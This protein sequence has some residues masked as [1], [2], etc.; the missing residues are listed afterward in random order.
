MTDGLYVLENGQTWHLT[1]S[2]SVAV[3]FCVPN[4]S[5]PFRRGYRRC[6]SCRRRQP[7]ICKPHSVFVLGSSSSSSPSSSMPM[8]G[9]MSCRPV[10][11]IDCSPLNIY[12]SA[13]RLG[14]AQRMLVILTWAQPS[15]LLFTKHY[16]LGPTIFST[17]GWPVSS[18]TFLK[19][20]MYRCLPWCVWAA[21]NMA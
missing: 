13:N 8:D 14:P 1:M 16:S 6:P 10:V 7:T 9:G 5:S 17:T 18:E 19:F 15:L 20:Q 2:V 21:E 11:T 4:P 12:F 3:G